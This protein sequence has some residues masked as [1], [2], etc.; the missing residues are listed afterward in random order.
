MLLTFDDG[1]HRDG[2]PAVLAELDRVGASAVF[3]VCGEQVERYPELVSEIVAA[4]HEL[5]LHGY[6]H[7]T[8]LQWG[9][10]LLADDMRRARAAVSDA[11][12]I[13]PRL[14]RPPLGVFSLAGT[15]VDPRAR[16]RAASLVEMGPRLGTWATSQTI[17]ARVGAGL[18]QASGPLH[19][20]DHYSA[21]GSWRETAAAI[22]PIADR[23]S[24]AG[25]KTAS[26]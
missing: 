18:G 9:G 6:R 12:G 15:Q 8:R 20:A 23:I 3:F 10:R 14:Y 16:A 22:G 24:A 1:P 5:G 17:T 26:V 2:T 25:L 4:G 19:D 11:A 13:E 21:D 7:W